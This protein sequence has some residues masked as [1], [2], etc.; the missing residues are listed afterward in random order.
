MDQRQTFFSHFYANNITQNFYVLPVVHFTFFT[1]T[2][3]SP[4]AVDIPLRAIAHR[5]RF[6]QVDHSNR[7]RTPFLDFMTVLVQVHIS[8]NLS[9][10]YLWS[11]V[12][13]R[14]FQIPGRL[15]CEVESSGYRP[16]SYCIQIGGN[17]SQN[18]A[19]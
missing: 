12:R 14:V 16:V 3:Q 11:T 19:W 17:Y 4:V 18:R 8:F 2:R 5:R 1:H 9:V 6:M 7:L 13:S 10:I 15:F